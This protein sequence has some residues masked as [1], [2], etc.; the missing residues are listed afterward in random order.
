MR[1]DTR[2]QA[3]EDRHE[4]SVGRRRSDRTR[5]GLAAACTLLAMA[6]SDGA[7]DSPDP[8]PDANA[9]ASANATPPR[10]VEERRAIL[11]QARAAQPPTPTA[12]PVAAGEASE[13]ATELPGPILAALKADLAQRALASAGEITIV[14]ATQQEWPDGSLGCPAPGQSYIQ[15]VTSGYRVVLAIADQEYDYRSNEQGQFV[16]CDRGR[17]LAPAATQIEGEAP[18]S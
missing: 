3:N 16:L 11:D 2:R 13:P 6:C 9:A 17:P 7:S 14:E 12:Q 18:A 10:S 15:Q 5:L 8:T 1:H 4:R